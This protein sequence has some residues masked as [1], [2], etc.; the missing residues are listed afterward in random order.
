MFCKR[1]SIKSQT[2]S[3]PNSELCAKCTATAE[4]VIQIVK[5][6]SVLKSTDTRIMETGVVKQ[7]IYKHIAAVILNRKKDDQSEWS[8]EDSV[9]NYFDNRRGSPRKP[10]SNSSGVLGVVEGDVGSHLADE[11]VIG[12]ALVGDAAIAVTETF[13]KLHRS[14]I[15]AQKFAFLHDIDGHDVSNCAIYD[16]SSSSPQTSARDMPTIPHNNNNS[17]GATKSRP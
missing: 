11:M 17:I 7:T 15:E 13:S 1:C 9:H 14:I 6:G 5:D 12:D 16:D 4:L 2:P 10:P 3:C 8:I